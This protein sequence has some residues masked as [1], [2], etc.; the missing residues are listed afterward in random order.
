MADISTN[1]LLDTNSFSPGF[2]ITWS[3]EFKLS[4]VDSNATGGFST[5]LF[6]NSK[7]TGGGKYT[8][9]AYAPY[10]ATTGVAGAIVGVMITNDAKFIVNNGSNFTDEDS[11]TNLL[12]TININSSS[13]LGQD[14]LTMRF[15][16]TDSGQTFNVAIKNPVT[17]TYKTISTINT[18]LITT[19]SDFYKIGLGFSTP[20]ASSD[21]KLKLTIKN[22]VIQG[23]TTAP[24]TKVTTPPFVFPPPETHYVLQSPVSGKISIGI[25]TP[26]V[27]GYILY[28]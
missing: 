25:P 2:D 21:S 1:S 11:I 24:T 5:F 23:S 7:L 27:D 17:D 15:N 3:F 14:Y 18:G 16:L 9:L 4:S 12:K 13:L 28:K 19:N 8:G 20:L 10:A 22:T 26:T 6:K